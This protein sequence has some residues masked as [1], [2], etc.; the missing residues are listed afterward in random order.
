M[1]IIPPIM[2]LVMKKY[3]NVSYIA[4]SVLGVILLFIVIKYIKVE[5]IESLIPQ[6]IGPFCLLQTISIK[7]LCYF[8]EIFFTLGYSLKI[9]FHVVVQVKPSE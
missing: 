7:W 4:A 3:L 5:E 2:S 1:P 6:Q 9:L 8:T